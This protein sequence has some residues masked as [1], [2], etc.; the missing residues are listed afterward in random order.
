MAWADNCCERLMGGNR[1]ASVPGVAEE[2]TTLSSR[3]I[4]IRWGYVTSQI[5]RDLVRSS[6]T[7]FAVN[8]LMISLLSM[9]VRVIEQTIR[10]DPAFG[11]FQI[12]KLFLEYVA[13]P[14]LPSLR[15]HC[16]NNV[17]CSDWIALNVL[18][19]VALSTNSVAASVEPV[20]QQQFFTLSPMTGQEPF[21]NPGAHSILNDT[22]TTSSMLAALHES[23]SGGPLD[24]ASNSF[25]SDS[26]VS[27]SYVEP[28]GTHDEGM[29]NV[30]NMFGDYNPTASF[31]VSSFTPDL[32][33]MG[34]DRVAPPSSSSEH[35]SPEHK[36]ES[37]KDEATTAS[38]VTST[39]S[40]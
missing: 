20:I 8:L 7:R 25:N 5:M 22:P 11:A 23:F 2:R 1:G 36:G 13:S 24:A 15:F 40:A 33:G 19:S 28:N 6:N 14:L 9:F 18:R 26:Y 38:A 37:V 39:V 10:S 27:M 35:S 16:F 31:D 17:F 21:P 4:L 32:A 34:T 12:L 29:S 3:S 30:G